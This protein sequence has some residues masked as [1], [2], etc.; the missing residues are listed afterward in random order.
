MQGKQQQQTQTK[1][2]TVPQKPQLLFLLKWVLVAL[3]VSVRENDNKCSVG[4][5]DHALSSDNL[6][7]YLKYHK[8]IIYR[9]EGMLLSLYQKKSEVRKVK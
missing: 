8:R 1:E 9:Q 7:F 4:S 3:T 2:Y 6:A 5:G